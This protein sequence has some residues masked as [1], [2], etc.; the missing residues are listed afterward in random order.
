MNIIVVFVLFLIHKLYFLYVERTDF[1]LDVLS[2][3]LFLFMMIISLSKLG[4]HI[5]MIFRKH[6]STILTIS[7]LLAI[8]WF[9]KYYL[10]AG[11]FRDNKPAFM[12]FS[13]Q[14]SYYRMINS[15]VNGTF[16]R[17]DYLYGL[18][19]PVL[20]AVFYHLYENDPLFYVNFICYLLIIIYFYNFSKYF[21]KRE[22]HVFLITALLV[23][24]PY[25]VEYL[26]VPWTST[27]TL[28]TYSYSLYI[29]LKQKVTVFE[30][31][32]LG[33]CAGLAFAT[34]Y[35][36]IILFLP[37]GIYLLSSE[38]IT[39]KFKGLLRILPAIVISFSIALG[40]FYSHKV[41]F[42]DYFENPYKLH[43]HPSDKYT[44]GDFS[45]Y[46]SRLGANII[47]NIYGQL[48]E[49]K[50]PMG[51][52]Y[53]DS[54]YKELM[55]SVFQKNFLFLFFP[56]GF[57]LMLMNKPHLRLKLSALLIGVLLFLF[58]YS[59]HPGTCSG[60][61]IFQS[62]HY[63]KPL[64]PLF[65]IGGCYYIVLILS[66]SYDYMKLFLL[67]ALNLLIYI[68]LA[69]FIGLSITHSYEVQ[70]YPS[71]IYY[72]KLFKILIT[73][74]N[75]YG[76]VLKRAG[77]KLSIVCD[78]LDD[79]NQY[80]LFEVPTDYI[81]EKL[82]WSG[83]IVFPKTNSSYCNLKINDVSTKTIDIQSK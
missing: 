50:S 19:Y 2:V 38:I 70:L 36:D 52:A 8:I 58:I 65:M 5:D 78:T 37:I 30:Y 12:G 72:D 20:G 62:T 44:D 57:I 48:V 80:I 49:G 54:I 73:P 47:E 66:G 10:D 39:Y 76:S 4:I 22:L 53:Q 51:F 25:L 23:I 1:S 67:G 27:I 60:C 45:Y 41:Y 24:N 18:G 31:A 75:L 16:E 77:D 61:M 63:F 26:V 81:S 7:V 17:S 15:L 40:V 9:N 43:H 64:I 79:K 69:M 13:D 34:R 46:Y 3:Y 32:L 35:V 28:M 11:G 82:H 56:A 33:L 6:K 29:F 83:D 55:E 71:E 74:K 21:F 14:S 68:I 42:G 59:L